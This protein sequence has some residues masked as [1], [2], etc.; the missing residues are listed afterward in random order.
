VRPGKAVRK[1]QKRL[2]KGKEIW[3]ENVIGR[4]DSH[5]SMKNYMDYMNVYNILFEHGFLGQVKEQ[6]LLIHPE[7]KA[8]YHE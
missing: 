7:Q 4:R 2:I 6:S 3:K 1:K 5:N 8:G